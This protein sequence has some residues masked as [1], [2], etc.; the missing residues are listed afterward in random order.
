MKINLTQPQ[1][2]LAA[3]IYLLLL[4]LLFS[5]ID[6]NFNE[7]LFKSS[8][9]KRVWF[10]SGAL[11]I[12]L[13][14]YIAEPFFSKPTDAIA[15]S[16][17]V[18]I[19]L[20]TLNDKDRFT[21][22]KVILVL[23]ILVL[24]S[25]LI[26][27]FLKNFNQENKT[28]QRINASAYKIATD[29]GNYKVL[30]SL[31]YLSTVHTYFLNISE[32]DII[33]TIVLFAFWY[34][35]I[36][37][38]IVGW[39]IK[40]FINLVLST[41]DD[42]E[43]DLG[44]AIGCENPLLY[45]VEV[46]FLK[47]KSSKI[48]IGDLVTVENEKLNKSVGIVINK[49]QLLNKFWLEVYLLVDENENVI[50]MPQVHRLKFLNEKKI[51]QFKNSVKKIKTLDSLPESNRNQVGNNKLY[52]KREN[53]VGYIEKGSNI[54][55]II[56]LHLGEKEIKEGAI[57][58][59]EIYGEEVLFQVIDGQTREEPLEFK[60]GYGYEVAYARKIGSYDNKNKELKVRNWLPRIYT[61]V[62]VFESEDL[63]E[64]RLLEIS[65]N[66]I[67]RLPKTTFEIPINDYNSLVTHNTAI[68]GI[69]GIGKSRLTFE[70]LKKLINKTGVKI[71]CIDVTKQYQTEL[72]DYFEEDKLM[73]DLSEEELKDLK[74]KNADGNFDNP[75]SWGNESIYREKLDKC[76]SDFYNSESRVLILN[77]D[78]HNVSVAGSKFK[79]THKED[80]TIAQKTRIISERAFIYSYNQGET[81]DA[82]C[83]IVFEEAHSLIPEWNS[84]A[85]DGDKTA[86][87]GTAKVILQGRKFGLGSLVI[88][89]RTA[90]ISKSILNQCNT[91]FALRVF[92]DTGKQFLENYIGSDY[93]NILPTLEERHAIAVG[94]AL[95]LKQPVIIELND[96]KRVTN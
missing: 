53:F 93:S 25:S 34:I 51:L 82:R 77:P 94:K 54:N 92:D 89:Q 73:I 75:T 19:T 59:S 61:P 28:I 35:L 10:F 1:R 56:F 86:V 23:A 46:D 58:V 44:L 67:G 60:D 68:L 43:E 84:V 33:S 66:S 57:V 47:N 42:L 55:Q 50:K 4:I 38:D 7:L 26:T 95:K 31:V 2:T 74:A 37:F 29:I 96:M 49:K 85:N 91:I 69:L 63:S 3:I 20:L 71:I 87:N 30:F 79:I 22:Y 48:D 90:N 27:I 18:I 65:N 9:D 14:K 40:T 72:L 12:I 6:G 80:L 11:L 15:N 13:G 39:F 32:P 64:E 16:A 78:W 88:T 62:F 52:R 81:T 17:A 83:M 36:S 76:I 45:K 41:S 70:I 5:L 8:D 21:L 24:I